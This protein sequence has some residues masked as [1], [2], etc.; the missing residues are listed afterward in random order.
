ML[1]TLKG[2]L[3]PIGFLLLLSVISVVLAFSMPDN[4]LFNI[5]LV[6]DMLMGMHLIHKYFMDKFI[7]DYLQKNNND[8]CYE[9]FIEK[10]AIL[11]GDCKCCCHKE[12]AKP[13]VVKAG[14]VLTVGTVVSSMIKLRWIILLKV[15][16]VNGIAISQIPKVRQIILSSID[17]KGKKAEKKPKQEEEKPAVVGKEDPKPDVEVKVEVKPEEKKNE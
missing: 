10:L 7:T 13:N 5:F 16:I 8:E 4:L 11:K 15:I 1:L 9:K 12:G 2:H 6:A 14:I 17:K 3:V